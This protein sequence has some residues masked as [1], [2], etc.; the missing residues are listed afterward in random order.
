MN[1][2]INAI[3]FKEKRK[4]KIIENYKFLRCSPY[5]FNELKMK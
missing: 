1:N 4:Q 2:K 5:S 3:K